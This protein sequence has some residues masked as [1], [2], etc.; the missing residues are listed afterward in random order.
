M[1]PTLEQALIIGSVIGSFTYC[2][3]NICKQVQHS[4]CSKIQAC[5]CTIEREIIDDDFDPVD[6]PAPTIITQQ[7]HHVSP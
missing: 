1:Y 7:P 4:R 3:V 6:I 2:V 5:C